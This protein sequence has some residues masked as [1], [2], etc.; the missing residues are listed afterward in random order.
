VPDSATRAPTRSSELLKM[1]SPVK[2]DR[3]ALIHNI[4]QG[5]LALSLMPGFAEAAWNA[6]AAEGAAAPPCILSAAQ[7][8]MIAIIA[9]AILPRS[10]TPGATDVGVLPWIDLVVAEYFSD[11]RRAAFQADLTAIDD[12]ALSTSG[13]P[14]TELQGEAQL[15]VIAGLDAACGAKDLSFAQRGYGELKELVIYGYFTSKPVQQDILQVVV[16]PGRFD[17]NVLIAPSS[18][19]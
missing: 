9:D 7:T 16:V 18:A 6:I 12:F 10:D 19:T 11:V 8:R 14:F 4:V 3:R 17:G 15:A 13:A 5:G 2:L 1:P